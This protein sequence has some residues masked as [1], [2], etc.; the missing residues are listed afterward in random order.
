MSVYGH[1]GSAVPTKIGPKINDRVKYHGTATEYRV[2]RVNEDGSVALVSVDE[3][4]TSHRST[5][6]LLTLVERAA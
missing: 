4:I 1:D 5:P 3:P 6:R 2:Q